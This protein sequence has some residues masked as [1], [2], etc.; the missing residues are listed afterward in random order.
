MCLDLLDPNMN[1]TESAAYVCEVCGETFESEA[2]LE[3]HVHD[4]GLVD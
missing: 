2:E 1:D 4:K 3:G